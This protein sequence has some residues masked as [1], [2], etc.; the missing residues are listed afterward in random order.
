MTSKDDKKKEWAQL[1][2][3]L[4]SK[5]FLFQRKKIGPPDMTKTFDDRI[6]D[7]RDG[8]QQPLNDEQRLSLPPISNMNHLSDYEGSFCESDA[9]ELIE[10]IIKDK[11]AITRRLILSNEK[12]FQENCVEA[13]SELSR[14]YRKVKKC[15]NK[16]T[17][18]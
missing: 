15:A 3:P 13:H 8:Y 14:L 17:K 12:T 18:E 5:T 1:Y 6:F 10:N 16:V 9:F 7:A 11:D 4:N 2:I